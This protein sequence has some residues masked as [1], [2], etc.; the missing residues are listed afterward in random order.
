MIGQFGV[1]FYSAYLVSE[2]VQVTTKVGEVV[3][4]GK[5]WSIGKIEKW[6]VHLLSWDRD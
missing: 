1:G 6:V 5:G 2:R 3:L 4:V